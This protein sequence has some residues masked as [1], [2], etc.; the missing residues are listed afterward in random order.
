M[1]QSEGGALLAV[2]AKHVHGVGRE[3]WGPKVG[4]GGGGRGFDGPQNYLGIQNVAERRNDVI[5]ES[6]Q[7]SACKEQKFG[8]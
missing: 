6:K 1:S 4:V 7:G 3:T 8:T 5:V 2:Q